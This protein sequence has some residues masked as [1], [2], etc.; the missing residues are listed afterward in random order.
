MPGETPTAEADTSI[1]PERSV[2]IDDMIAAQIAENAAGST[3]SETPSAPEVD[4]PELTD[5]DAIMKARVELAAASGVLPEAVPKDF[6]GLSG[7]SLKAAET[8]TADEVGSRAQARAEEIVAD[9]AL[10]RTSTGKLDGRTR[11]VKVAR[12]QLEDVAFDAAKQTDE[13]YAASRAV[14]EKDYVADVALTQTMAQAEANLR[15]QAIASEAAGRDLQDSDHHSEAAGQ[16]IKAAE[17]NIDA[18]RVAS[19]VQ[20]VAASQMEVADNI[21]ARHGSAAGDTVREGALERGA[22][23]G[24]AIETTLLGERTTQHAAEQALDK[25]TADKVAQVQLIAQ[26]EHRGLVSQVVETADDAAVA[27]RLMSGYGRAKTPFFEREIRAKGGKITE[28]YYH[29]DTA[30]SEDL[31]MVE[32]Y[33]SSSGRLLEV[34]ATK[35]KDGKSVE[36]ETAG[37]FGRRTTGSEVPS[38]AIMEMMKVDQDQKVGLQL[39]PGERFGNVDG[40]VTQHILRSRGV[41]DAE[42][43]D[44][45]GKQAARKKANKP[46][47][48]FWQ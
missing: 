8:A 4:T 23:A 47:W 18:A 37:L 31:L 27:D 26:G 10:T 1:S 40:D 30:G 22:A 25:R 35:A 36:P 13:V 41:T 32:R 33:S 20:K 34:V 9:P 44:Y 38:K 46:I 2:E 15:N 29:C 48:A 39:Q 17:Q 45:A 11:A 19:E 28:L 7:R 5:T 16:F 42:V 21:A 43:T 6:D 24:A 3:S 12:G 14:G